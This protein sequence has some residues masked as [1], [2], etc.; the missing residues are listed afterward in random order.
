MTMFERFAAL[1][2]AYENLVALGHNPFGMNVE[3]VLSPTEAI[4]NGR[5]M[6]MAGT[7]NYLGLTFDESC[8]A[9]AAAALKREGTGTTGSRI[10]NGT[11]AAHRELEFEL[12]RFLGRRSCMVFSTGYQ[13]NL[14]ALSTLAGP[15]DHI[16]IDADAH[17]SIVDGCRLGGAQV[18][19]FRHNDPLDLEKR[20]RR[21]PKTGNKLI[22][23]EGIYSMLGDTACLR[24]I[25]EVKRRHGAYLLV[26]E[27]HSLGVLGETGR[28]LVEAEG[29]DADVEFIVGTFSKS[30]GSVGGFLASNHPEFD[31]LRVACR[32]YM[33]TASLPPSTIAG[34]IAALR[35]IQKRPE[36]RTQL[37]RNSRSLY[38]GLTRLGFR[39]GPEANPVV[40]VQLD[41][42]DVAAKFW[43]M[44]VDSGLYVNLMLPPAT[45]NG[46][47]LLRCSVCAKHTPQQIRFIQ[48][49]FYE[50][51]VALG[52]LAE[53]RLVASA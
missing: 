44:L 47:A 33:F 39:L 38:D 17:A 26:D 15:D 53:E 42:P 43:N 4:V 6:L 21:L 16:I 37:M 12:A 22:V 20:L 1:G 13:A 5:R 51:G 30:L 7:N 23:V 50:A 52:V 2:K 9:E 48:D 36:L 11:Y 31:V 3:R 19:R 29:V 27:A 28:G 14:G 41:S 45:P 24:E 25:V 34:T 49:A 32:T 46:T 8:V 40:A 18:T 35:A 10:A